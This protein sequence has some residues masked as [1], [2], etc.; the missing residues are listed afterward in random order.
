[1]KTFRRYKRFIHIKTS[2]FTT[3]ET[4]SIIADIKDHQ[5]RQMKMLIKEE[6]FSIIYMNMIN[7]EKI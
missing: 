5:T 7:V 3:S 4:C 1:M 2:Q 6:P